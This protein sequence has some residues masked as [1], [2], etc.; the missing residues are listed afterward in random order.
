MLT[1]T[2]L[3]RE[4]LVRSMHKHGKKLGREDAGEAWVLDGQVWLIE[5]QQAHKLGDY[6]E[7]LDM[8]RQGLRRLIPCKTEG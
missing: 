8:L 4:Q 5:A 6:F 3:A 1:L 2:G 7:Y